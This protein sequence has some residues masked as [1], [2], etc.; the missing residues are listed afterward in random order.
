MTA[1]CFRQLQALPPC[2][3]CGAE[4]QRGR[5]RRRRC[6][7]R[8][9]WREPAVPDASPLDLGLLPPG[10]C[11]SWSAP[12]PE[13]RCRMTRPCRRSS[14]PGS[15]IP[16]SHPS[17]AAVFADR[18]GRGRAGCCSPG[19]AQRPA[20]LNRLLAQAGGRTSSPSPISRE[21]AGV[22][23]SGRG[24]RSGAAM[25]I[26]SRRHRDNHHRRRVHRNDVSRNPKRRCRGG[27]TEK[28]CW[29]VRHCPLWPRAASSSTSRSTAS[30]SR[31]ATCSDTVPGCAAMAGCGAHR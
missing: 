13:P 27:A 26:A 21:D 4:R 10:V 29:R 7:D 11:A 25:T 30:R 9:R 1:T 3:R 18:I 2:C 23:R 28:P 6:R 24:F 12:G 16:T 19:S 20:L 15:S 8:P 5:V 31:S 17:K 22:R 14:L